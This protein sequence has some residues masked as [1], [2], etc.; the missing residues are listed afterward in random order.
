MSLVVAH[1]LDEF[2]RRCMLELAKALSFLVC[3]LS[4]YWAAISAFFVP[5]AQWEERSGWPF[6]S[7]W[8]PPQSASTAAWYFP[9]RPGPIPPPFSA[10]RPPCRCG[11][12]SGPWQGIAVLFFL[13]WYLADAEAQA[14]AI[15]GLGLGALSDPSPPRAITF[16][17]IHGWTTCGCPARRLT[18][19]MLFDGD[20]QR[21]GVSR[22]RHS[23]QVGRRCPAAT[24]A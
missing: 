13:S 9:G 10:S 17:G 3:I 20:L 7:S 14:M 12:S 23:H 2:R 5:G 6:S 15:E 19:R 11:F 4:L 16:V 8:P 18:L 21:A 24:P 1:R 22:G